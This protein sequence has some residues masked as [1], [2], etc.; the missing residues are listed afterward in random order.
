ML[1]SWKA[2]R[3]YHALMACVE[4]RVV[5]R[6]PEYPQLDNWFR[7]EVIV[8]WEHVALHTSVA[9]PARHLDQEGLQDAR[10][11]PNAPPCLSRVFKFFPGVHHMNGKCGALQGGDAF[12]KCHLRRQSGLISG[13]DAFPSPGTCRIPYQRCIPDVPLQPLWCNFVQA[14]HSRN[15]TRA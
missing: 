2:S 11:T 13:S 6:V 5:R 10:R 14:T 12:P 7:L 8:I 3:Y 9:L 15:A 1:R 4:E